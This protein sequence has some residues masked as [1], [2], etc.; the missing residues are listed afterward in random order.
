M[1]TRRDKRPV[2]HAVG[3]RALKNNASSV[4]RRVR[5]GETITITDRNRPVAMLLPVESANLDSVIRQ[6][7]S[8]GR[9]SWEGGKPTGCAKPPSLA[10]A[11]LAEAVIEDRR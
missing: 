6:L 4:L 11:P 1:K 7:C 10:V 8:T 3:I 2:Q 5:A 9:L